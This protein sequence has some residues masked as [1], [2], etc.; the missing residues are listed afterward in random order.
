MY[1]GFRDYAPELARFTT[2]DPI[3]DGYNWYA[4]VGNNPVNFEA[5]DSPSIPRHRGLGF[6]A[7]SGTKPTSCRFALAVRTFLAYG[8][9]TSANRAVPTFRVLP[10]PGDRKA[11]ATDGHYGFS[12]AGAGLEPATSG[13]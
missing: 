9:G 4:Y 10:C 13:L 7:A 12:I 3:R 8:C 2:V 11:A 6:Q 1:D 5:Q